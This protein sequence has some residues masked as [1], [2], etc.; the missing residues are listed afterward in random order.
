MHTTNMM[1]GL[2]AVRYNERA[3]HSS[4]ESLIHIDSSFVSSKYWMFSDRR[5]DG[6]VV[7]KLELF[8]DLVYVLGLMYQNTLLILSNLKTQESSLFPQRAHL[9][10]LLHHSL[11]FFA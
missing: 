4:V 2:L 9:E 11:E 8:Q 3:Y 6:L 1:S 10:L 5:L 7:G